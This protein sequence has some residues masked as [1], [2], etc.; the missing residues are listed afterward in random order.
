M[1]VSAR[2][3]IA[4]MTMLAFTTSAMPQ[5]S[6][7]A[8]KLLAAPGAA[9]GPQP[10]TLSIAYSQY[11]WPK[12]NG[13][14]TVYY[15][16]DSQS[17]PNATAK[18]QAALAISNADFPGVLQWVPWSASVGPNYVDINLSASNTSGICEANEGYEAIPAQPMSG[19]TD[20][21]IGTI[22]H[23]MGHVIGLWH[24]QSRSDRNTYITVNYSNVI[25]S[26]WSNF[27]IVTDDEQILSSYDYASVMEYIPFAFSSNGGPVIESIPAG[28][29]M[30]GY[31]GV[32][33]QAGPTG[34]PALPPFDYSAGDKETILRLYGAAPTQITVTSN[35]VGLSV[36]VDGVTVT[37]PQTYA[38]PLYST[39]TLNVASEVQTLPGYILNS[40]PAVAATFYYTYGRWSNSA[41]QSQSITVIPGNGSSTF[42]S[43]APALSTYSAN[44]IQLSP[45]SS[46]VYPAATGQVTVSPQPQLY[47]GATGPLFVAREQATLTATA[48][49]GWSFYEFNN[50]PFWLPGDLGANPKTFYVPDSGNPVNTLAE[51]SNLPIYTVDLQPQTFSSNLYAYVDSGFI[52]TP[53]NFSPYY[54]SS[55]TP[56]STH[57]LN[58]DNP[59]YPYSS[60]SRFNFLSWSDG[61]AQSHS[62]ASLPAAGTSYVATVTPEYRPATNFGY[63]PCGGSAVLSPSSPTNDGFYPT[64]QQLSFT[65]T[66]DAGWSFA[67]WS[68]DLTGVANPAMLTADDETLVFANFNTVATALTLTSISPSSA[69]VGGSAFTLTL[70]GTG[71]TASSLVSANGQY[72]TVDFVSSRKLTVPMTAADLATLGG[73]QVFVENYPSGWKGCAVF[74]YQTFLVTGAGP[75]AAAPSFSPSAGTYQTTQS[76]TIS[77]A[78]P[79]K[80]MYYTTNGSKPTTRSTPYT[81]AISVSSTETIKAIA[82]ASGF[83]E[84]PVATA[85]Y[86]IEPLA[87]TPAFSPA[88]GTYRTA[89]SVTISDTTPG[90]T[91]H[92]TLN[93]AQPTAKSP[94]YT[95]PIAISKTETL[96]AIALASGYA[97]SDT[98]SGTYTIR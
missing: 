27:Q 7:G 84:S 68:Y 70:I 26:A 63:P 4:L 56:G 65:A 18:I 5:A 23:E 85:T 39:H 53:K 60:N 62:I 89:Q 45:Y 42:P 21:T 43:K 50:S 76:V 94:T 48:D 41:T 73:F 16:I 10:D 77:D 64:G 37:T 31:E 9:R 57:T 2:K 47:S 22:L 29:P 25:K 75:P 28:I 1:C 12:V 32:P 52:Y 80:E 97:E 71:F 61:G 87:A 59:E 33:S 35:P 40:N 58:L 13:V 96:K 82:V 6:A 24:E 88:A 98:A 20:C 19:S 55:W 67:G 86:T 34:T 36:V 51:F 92:Y 46:A 78:T 14:A 74:G 83:L 95:S 93:G 79:G 81:G 17:D 69:A 49:A 44:F 66:P 30:A 38:W 3:V 15:L 91:I 54:D 72:R 8:S 11:L 90:T